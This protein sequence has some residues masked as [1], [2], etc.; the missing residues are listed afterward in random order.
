MTQKEEEERIKRLN[1]LHK[2][3]PNQILP[4]K[5]KKGKLNYPYDSRYD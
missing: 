2:P 1:E 3:K 4:T 5:S